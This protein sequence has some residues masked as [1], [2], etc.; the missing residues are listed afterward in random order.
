M[1]RAIINAA[2]SAVLLAAPAAVLAASG[3]GGTGGGMSGGVHSSMSA[4]TRTTGLTPT[5]TTPNTVRGPSQTGQPKQSCQAGA[6]YPLN[7]PGNSFNAPGSAFNPNGT[8]GSVYA[9]NGANNNK[10]TAS[11]AQYDVACTR[12]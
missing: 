6:N 4:P 10:N 2:M 12:P 7:T 9:G 3:H 5:T 11:V 8:A 1:R